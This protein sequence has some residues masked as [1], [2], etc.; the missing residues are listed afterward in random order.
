MSEKNAAPVAPMGFVRRGTTSFAHDQHVRSLEADADRRR[1]EAAIDH[2]MAAIPIE[3]GGAK[4]TTHH[5]TKNPEV[6]KAYVLLEFVTNAGEPFIEKGEQLKALCDVIMV[7]GTELALII[8][9]PRCIGS[10]TPQGQ[11]QMQIRQSNR[12]FELDITP[13]K[14]LGDKLAGDFFRFDERF[15]RSAGLV[16][17]SE[18]FRCGN[19]STKYRIVKNTIRTED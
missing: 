17:E 18:P 19:C 9:C 1:H 14:T 16:R 10:G 11:A 8:P 12:H 2:R 13:S 4:M 7:G 15:Y 6:D 5:L 3:D